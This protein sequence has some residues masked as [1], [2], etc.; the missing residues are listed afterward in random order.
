MVRAAVLSRHTFEQ[1]SFER[2]V[3]KGR[4]NGRPRDCLQLTLLHTEALSSHGIFAADAT[5]EV[6]WIVRAQ[7]QL[8]TRFVQRPERMCLIAGEYVRRDVRRRAGLEDYSSVGDL[9]D[10][11]RVLDRADAVAEPGDG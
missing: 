1:G 4:L 7:C 11:R 3:R 6:G 2:I 10:Q 5:A 8:H 9:L